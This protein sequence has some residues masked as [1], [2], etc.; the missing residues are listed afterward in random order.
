MKAYIKFNL[1]QESEEYRLH[2]ASS[3]MYSFIF[4]FANHIREKL[5]HSD[6]TLEES[7]IYEEIK[8]KYWELLKDNEID[9]MF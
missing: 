9:N 7:K 5:K 6:L 2:N 8:D 3:D 1:P 4:D